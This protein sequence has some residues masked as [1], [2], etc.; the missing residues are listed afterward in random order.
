[1]LLVPA[2]LHIVTIRTFFSLSSYGAES[3]DNP[4]MSGSSLDLFFSNQQLSSVNPFVISRI[5]Q[6]LLP[7]FD[8]FFPLCFDGFDQLRC[9]IHTLSLPRPFLRPLV[10]VSFLTG[11]CSNG[12]SRLPFLKCPPFSMFPL[13]P[14]REVPFLFY[15]LPSL[16]PSN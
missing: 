7:F 5:F 14:R 3:S 8:D 9:G 4:S 11:N 15:P 10:P 13:A 1:V 16:C 6:F 12:L 2:L